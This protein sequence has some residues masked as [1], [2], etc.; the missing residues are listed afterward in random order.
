MLLV[1]SGPTGVGKSKIAVELAKVIGGEII[2]ADSVAVY[3]GLDIGTA[4]IT[5]NEM[6]G[7]PHHLIDILD[8]RAGFDAYTFKELAREK[9]R[10]I[11]GRGHIPIVVGGTGFYIQALCY[12]VDFKMVDM[13]Y[14]QKLS[15]LLSEKGSMYLYEILM[16]KDPEYAAELSPNNEKR[17][18]RALEFIHTTGEKMSE[19]NSTERERKSPYDL[20]YF[21]LTKD[22][23]ALYADINARVDNMV[24]QGLLDEV[25]RAFYPVNENTFDLYPPASA[26]GYKEMVSHILGQISLSGAIELIKQNTRHFAKRQMTWYRRER[27]VEFFDKDYFSDDGELVEYILEELSN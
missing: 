4:K 15:N 22:R 11:E 10:E 17:L 13:V 24:S 2:S 14:R 27:D 5:K 3:R 16:K 20:R 23:G 19:H 8:V 26:I 21:V 25:K 12:D 9:I 7:I 18:I 6:Q 1:L